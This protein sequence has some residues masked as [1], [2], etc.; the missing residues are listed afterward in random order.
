MKLLV[1][2]LAL[3]VGVL[4]ACSDSGGGTTITEPRLPGPSDAL[5][6]YERT[7]GI[8]GIRERL[9]VRRDGVARVEAGY[10]GRPR[11]KVQRV[12]LTPAELDR[13]RAAHDAVDWAG[14]EAGYGDPNAVADGFNTKLASDGRTVAVY[15]EGDPPAEL[16]RLME[17]CAGIVDAYRRR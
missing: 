11:S 17:V 5:V 1:P 16:E 7:G 9:D 4:V 15:T 3:T 8:A 10:P 13:L 6:S 14:L 2:V 12:E